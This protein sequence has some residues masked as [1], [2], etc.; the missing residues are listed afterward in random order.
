MKKRILSLVLCAA[1][2]LSMCLFLGA[3][4]TDDTTAEGSAEATESYIPA[5]N[6][7]NVAP[8]VQANAQAANGPA[9]APMLAANANDDS[10]SA[11]KGVVTSKTATANDDGT[12]TITL[13]SYTTGTVRPLTTS[14]P[15]DI[16]LVLDQ[17]GSM[18]EKFSEVS[19]ANADKEAGKT[20]GAYLTPEDEEL[21]YKDGKWEYYHYHYGFFGGYQWDTYSGNTFYSSR[22]LALK[23]AA[24]T[25]VD[26]VSKEATKNDVDH[27]IAIVGF[28]STAS[29]GENYENTELLSTN[30]VVNYGS[31]TETDYKNALV[32]VN[33]TNG[34]INS[35]LTTAIGQLDANGDTYSE[36]GIDMAN[37][38]F[39]QHSTESE[40]GR[41][42]VVVVFTDG[43]TA[44]S[45]TNAFKYSMADAAIKKANMSKND[46][47]ATVYTI[48][49]FANANPAADIES[50]FQTS[51]GW[52]KAN[53]NKKAGNA[54]NSAQELVAA[55]RYMHY[56][57]SN[58]P[59]AKSL[60]DGGDL[61]DKASPFN[62]GDSY[63]LSAGDADTL[64]NIFK[65]ISNNIST[66]SINLGKQAYVQDT[67][68]PYFT[69]PKESGEIKVYAEKAAYSGGKYTWTRDDD[70]TGMSAKV[71]GSTVTVSGFDYDA[72]FV[73]QTPR[74]EKDPTSRENC[75]FYGRRLVVTFT[76]KAEPGF[77][78]GNDVLTNDS[79][80]I[81]ASST[82]TE[83]VCTF[84]DKPKVNVPIKDVTVR[85]ADKNVYLLDG[86]TADQL[87]ADA[88][89]KVGDVKLDLTKANDPDHPYGL[90][91]WQTDYVNI[92]VTIKDKDGN[93]ISAM[94]ELRDDVSYTIEVTVA[95][96]TKS[97]SSKEGN[98]AVDKRGT[99]T[100]NVNVFKPEL[101]FKDSEGYYGD[102]APT[103][104][105]D[106]L[107]S[108]VWKH[109]KTEANIAV[110]GAV[111]ELTL[112]F[113]PD[114]GAVVDGKIN[115]RTDFGVAAAVK[116]GETDVTVNTT[117]QHTPCEGKTCPLPKGTAFLCHVNTCS[118]TIS[119]KVTGDGAN[120]NQTFVF[121]VKDKDDKV[122]TTVVL[123]AG[124]NT[125]ITGLAVGNYTVV[126]DTAW[127]WSYKAAENSEKVDVKLSGTKPNGEAK[128]TNTAKENHWLTSIVDVINKWKAK[129]DIDNTGHVPGPG[130]N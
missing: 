75:D 113:T 13:T 119:K 97:P 22:L 99:A 102:T 114:D 6:F 15:T 49:I 65:K 110:M 36:Y 84:D 40:Q 95:P 76:V 21:R 77:L 125:T 80:D 68:S 42:R 57:S 71:N 128:I 115:T 23:T 52:H 9:R 78:G 94:S 93:V 69:A 111:P 109:G 112:A 89:V 72:N 53:G 106:N 1:T 43:Y 51:D 118:L 46:Y 35:R 24:T 2:L 25:F 10:G 98:Q 14:K 96:K 82:E 120:P 88:T 122:V 123:K 79:A 41:Q 104:F 116:I 50:N 47:K 70:C 8:F 81:Y 16:V 17:S 48:G 67:V 86:L 129:D 90:E 7:T 103:S 56:V 59:N 28:A 12:Y 126:E 124:T 27:R 74:N 31:A 85:D 34:K 4:V 26:Q 105:K 44:P 107:T 30:S 91:K 60:N 11:N 62:S 33:G 83:P 92:T 87:K 121:N 64:N 108:T 130:T 37:K 39:A 20:A 127:S 38:I 18:A 19:R 101:T 55:N 58:Y 29:A 54:L 61:S 45:G 117:F 100:A 73:S 5:V 3:G 32:S 66:P 63:Y